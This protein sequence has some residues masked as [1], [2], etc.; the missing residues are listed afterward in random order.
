MNTR[1]SHKLWHY[2]TFLP[3]VYAALGLIM[4]MTSYSQNWGG[5]PK[6]TTVIS[7]FFCETLMVI[8]AFAVLAYLKQ[9][10]RSQHAKKVLFLNIALILTGFFTGL[11]LFLG[12]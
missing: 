8:S 6:F 2:V 4:V 10:Q 9:S 12:L 3:V 5:D 1:P 7:V 11:Y